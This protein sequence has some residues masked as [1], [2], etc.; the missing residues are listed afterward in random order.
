MLKKFYKKTKYKLTEKELTELDFSTI[1][2]YQ[3]QKK[4][5]KFFIDWFE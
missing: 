5:G 3:S 1:K 2:S 4:K